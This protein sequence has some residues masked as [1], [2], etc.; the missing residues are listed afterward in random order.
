MGAAIGRLA[1]LPLSRGFAR[2]AETAAERA[3]AHVTVFRFF[4]GF[5]T[6]RALRTWRDY[7]ATR[8]ETTQKLLRVL[9]Q[10]K[11]LGRALHRWHDLGKVA[12]LLRRAARRCQVL[13]VVAAFSTM[14]TL[15]RR[16]ALAAKFGRRLLNQ[17]TSRAF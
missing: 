3:E 15:R 2:W 5:G 6:A 7:A 13:R 14:D 10:F 4:Q 16:S 8:G 1:H 9:N 12:P 11:P 17:A